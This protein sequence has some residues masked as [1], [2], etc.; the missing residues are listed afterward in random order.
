[1]KRNTVLYIS[2]AVIIMV[3]SACTT[4]PDTISVEPPMEEDIMVVETPIVPEK[5]DAESI[6]EAVLPQPEQEE[7]QQ[8]TP[9]EESAAVVEEAKAD[10]VAEAA[11]PVVE[12][13]ALPT[14]PEIEKFTEQDVETVPETVIPEPIPI[15]PE[16]AVISFTVTSDI[17][18]KYFPFDYIQDIES[19]GSLAQIYTYIKEIREKGNEIVLLDNGNILQGQPLVYYYNFVKTASVHFTAEVMNAMG[20]EA[21]SPGFHDIETGHGVYDKIRSEFSFPWLA[22]NAVHEGSG[23]PYFEPYTIIERNGVRAAVIGLITPEIPAW[24]P[25]DVWEGIRFEDP[26]TS[27]ARWIDYIKQNEM[28]DIIIGMY[29]PGF[30]VSETD[31][32]EKEY[33]GQ[34]VFKLAEQVPGFDIL[35]SGNNS[36]ALNTVVQNSEGDSVYILGGQG[37]GVSFST[38]DVRFVRAPE[39]SS[40]EIEEITPSIIDTENFEPDFEA[41]KLYQDV[42]DE[43]KAYVSKKIGIISSTISTTDALFGDSEFMDLIHQ[44]QLDLTGADVSFAAPM[45]PNAEIGKGDVFVRDMFNLFPFENLLYAIEMTGMEIDAYLEYSY[46]NWFSQ[47]V[48]PDGFL[49]PEVNSG[50]FMAD[51]PYYNFDSAAGIEYIVD[52]SKPA[53]DRVTITGLQ[54]SRK[55]QP[56]KMDKVYLV[57]V[58]SYRGNGGGGH[59]TEGAGI[60]R[61]ELGERIL[62]STLQDL[63]FYAIRLFEYSGTILPNSDGNWKI[64]PENWGR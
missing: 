45:S 63:R 62:Y 31:P 60:P 17:H 59:L 55:P 9:E 50:S 7:L 58:N 39:N 53:G 23:K 13:P 49:L 2:I 56:F 21:A 44:L 46:D 10:A 54:N 51:I 61:E 3:V 27:A 48:D 16:T 26:L 18:G 57:A 11:D 25:P 41:L 52:V 34:D 37:E 42:N 12:E 33:H 47:L 43:V 20:Y 32:G 5:A 40:F 24:L 1:M 4:I 38:V 64:V 22:A 29:Q 15:E 6:E 28:P 8:S 30:S 14:I 19:P 36:E 35:F